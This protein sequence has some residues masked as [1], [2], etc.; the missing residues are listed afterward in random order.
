M[1]LSD[2]G[3][4]RHSMQ[5]NK[6]REKFGLFYSLCSV[7]YNNFHFVFWRNLKSSLNLSE[8]STVYKIQFTEKEEDKRGSQLRFCEKYI[9]FQCTKLALR[10][11]RLKFLMLGH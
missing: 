7:N 1:Y 6:R 2:F 4:N 11:R 5:N 3:G 10:K 9:S 8:I